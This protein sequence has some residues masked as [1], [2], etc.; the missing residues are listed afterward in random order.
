MTVHSHDYERATTHPTLK[1]LP[2]EE[3]TSNESR[4]NPSGEAYVGAGHPDCRYRRGVVL[5]SA[6]HDRS[7]GADAVSRNRHGGA[8]QKTNSALE[9]RGEWPGSPRDAGPCG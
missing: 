1:P 6:F 3:G 9:R 4:A 8:A 7:N 2:S 5:Q